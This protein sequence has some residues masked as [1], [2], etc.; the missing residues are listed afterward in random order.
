MGIIFVKI[1][2]G[3]N[4]RQFLWKKNFEERVMS[5]LKT[6]NSGYFILYSHFY[7]F[8]YFKI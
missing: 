1:Q 6:I 5:E 7:L 3:E 8:S 4:E 2:I